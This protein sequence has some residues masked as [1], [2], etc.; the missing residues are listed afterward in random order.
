V[1]RLELG[2]HGLCESERPRQRPDHHDEF[3]DQPVIAR[4]Q[5]VAPLD[6]QIAYT[7]LEDEGV[8]GRIG[9]TDLTRVTEV[10]KDARDREQQRPDCVPSLVG[11]EYD[12]AA[13]HNVLRQQTDRGLHVL[14]LD[15]GTKGVH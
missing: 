11:F 12:R 2:L 6:L 13:E 9:C 15:G 10:F 4:V 14:R 1:S 8:V 3:V 7:S 5:E